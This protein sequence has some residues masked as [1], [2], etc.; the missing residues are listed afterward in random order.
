MQTIN[1]VGHWLKDILDFRSVHELKMVRTIDADEVVLQNKKN[2]KSI[3]SVN[4]STKRNIFDI[5]I[6]VFQVQLAR[7]KL[8]KVIQK[9]SY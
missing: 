4:L 9:L 3:C 6:F 5:I 2:W 7:Q 8:V 1:R